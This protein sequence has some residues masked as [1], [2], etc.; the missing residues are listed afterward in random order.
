MYTCVKLPPRDLNPSLY[1]SHP[2]NTY[3]CGVNIAP[4]VC[5]GR[6]VLVINT[7]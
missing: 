3:T 2:T 4:R 6:V 1:P 7:K 5:G